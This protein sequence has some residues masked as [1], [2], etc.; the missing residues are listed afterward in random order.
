MK[1]QNISRFIFRR[2]IAARSQGKFFRA[3][4]FWKEFLDE[5]LLVPSSEIFCAADMTALELVA[6]SR[7]YYPV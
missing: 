4:S 5:R 7:V 2:V 1:N 3:Q 6:V